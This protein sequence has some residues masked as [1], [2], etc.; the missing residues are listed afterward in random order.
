M[1]EDNPQKGCV[2]YV[3]SEDEFKQVTDTEP[4][5]KP[6]GDRFRQ[7]ELVRK[8]KKD[9]DG[10]P[11]DHDKYARIQLSPIGSLFGKQVD[12]FVHTDYH[13]AIVQFEGYEFYPQ[14]MAV[15]K[16]YSK[17]S[18]QHMLKAKPKEWNGTMKSICVFGLVAA[19]AHI[20]NIHD[21]DNDDFSIRY[22]CPENIIFDSDNHP[23]LIHYVFGNEELGKTPNAYIPPE[24]H[25]N[26]KGPRYD[27]DVWA[28]GMILY[29]IVTGH[30]PYEGKNEDQI[31]AAITKGELPELPKK[32]EDTNHIIGIIQNCLDKTPTNRPLPYMILKHL[33][34]SSDDLFPGTDKVVYDNYRMKVFELTVQSE[35]S[36][37]YFEKEDS[38]KEADVDIF[39]KAEAGED[40]N[41]LVRAGRF[42][43]KGQGGVEKDEEKGFELY[44][45]AADNGYPIGMYNAALCLMQGRGCEKNLE[46]SLELMEKA[47]DLDLENAVVQYGIMV[48]DGIGTKK[49]MKKAIKIFQQGADKNY[50][51]CQYLLGSI[52]YDGC[53]ELKQDTKKA[54]QLFKKAAQQGYAEASADIAYHYYKTGREEDDDAKI[55][56]AVKLYRK[57]ARQRSVSACINLGKIYKEGKYVD[58]D[59]K[60]AAD[61]YKQAAK[62]KDVQGMIEYGVCL[63]NGIGV[64]KDPKAASTYYRDAADEGDKRGQHNYAKLL[65]DGEGVKQDKMQ[66][67]KYFK[68]AADQGVPNSMFYYAK[69]VI[70]GEGGVARDQASGKKYLIKYTQKVPKEKWIDGTKKLMK[71]IKMKV[72]DDSGSESEESD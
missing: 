28:I 60:Q 7:V 31:K 63:K 21:E 62:M 65:Y 15:T 10:E 9:P 42:Y 17:G 71:T 45:K 26:P 12:I 19:V 6:K 33:N 64:K 68:K 40:N 72:D 20:H 69:I 32:S 44:M 50:R 22:L 11:E 67:S 37:S 30:K 29:E 55:Q 53:P 51:K 5:L 70:N 3:V 47:S 2:E 14:H 54:L 27:E 23:R 38:S 4:I 56:E 52:Y 24:L 59:E 48:R 61:Y 34:E 8:F 1:A 36:K 46:E 58:K 13:P 25:E 41:A 18:L 35:E 57:A 39:A 43:Q 49:N 16:Y 66:A